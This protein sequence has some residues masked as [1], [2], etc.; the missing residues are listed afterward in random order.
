M[1]SLKVLIIIMLTVGCIATPIDVKVNTQSAA[2]QR[3]SLSVEEIEFV[4]EMQQLIKAKSLETLK[5]L[6]KHIRPRKRS[7]FFFW[8]G[9]SY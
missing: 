3:V 9:L 1:Q 7:R 4:I 6:K 8:K 2:T 5:L